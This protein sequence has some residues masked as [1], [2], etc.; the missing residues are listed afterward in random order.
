LSAVADAKSFGGELLDFE[1]HLPAVGEGGGHGEKEA[2]ASCF[3]FEDSV[4][5]LVKGCA[6]G[7]GC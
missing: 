4:P 1:Y 2:V 5:K 6:E 3:D 7:F